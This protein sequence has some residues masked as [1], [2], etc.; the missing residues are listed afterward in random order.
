[1]FSFLF[2][3]KKIEAAEDRHQIKEIDDLTPIFDYLYKEL[4]I[5]DLYKRPIL[6]ERLGSIA[7]QYEVESAED[8]IEIFKNSNDFHEKVID[9]V[10]VNETYF[11]REIDSLKWLVKLIDRENR[12]IRVLS[13]PSSDGAEVYSILIMLDQVNSQLLHK[14]EFIGIDVNNESIKKAK[15][16]IYNERELHKLDDELKYRYFEKIENGCEIKSSLKSYTKFINDNIFALSTDKYGSFDVVL[17]RNLFIYFDD[18][19]RKKATDVLYK[20]LKPD[21]YLMIGV[22]DRLYENSGFKK[23]SSFIY[24]KS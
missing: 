7:K 21:G 2:G 14:V 5:N 10:T 19:H 12:D 13:I 4:G 8:F 22:T 18:L 24:Q 9:A 23:V 1:M 20:M 17:S 15:K 6:H 3:K 11:F 16:G